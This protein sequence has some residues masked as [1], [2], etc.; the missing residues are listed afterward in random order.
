MVCERERISDSKGSSER[1][2]LPCMKEPIG[3]CNKDGSGRQAARGHK[4]L[5]VVPRLG[6][7]ALM[8]PGAAMHTHESE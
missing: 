1:R 6:L 3:L 5:V 7:V 2:V 4:C 8:E